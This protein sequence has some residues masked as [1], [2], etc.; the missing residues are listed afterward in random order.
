MSVAAAGLNI[1]FGPMT[2]GIKSTTQGMPSCF[3][4][5]VIALSRAQL[6][7]SASQ[8]VRAGRR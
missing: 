3:H 4:L 7:A 5:I 8:A 6:W 1:C 2:N